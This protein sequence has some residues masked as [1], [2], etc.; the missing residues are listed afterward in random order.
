MYE[1]HSG[2]F[3]LESSQGRKRKKKE[4]KKNIRIHLVD[5]RKSREMRE[6]R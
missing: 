3:R 4:K 2:R 1:P 6:S 5:S